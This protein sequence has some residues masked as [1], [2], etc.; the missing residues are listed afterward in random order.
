MPNYG[1]HLARTQ[2]RFV[3]AL[4]ELFLPL[5]AARKIQCARRIP[6]DVFSYSGQRRLAEQVVSIRSFLQNAGR[7]N[8]F[9]VVSDGS[10]SA[11]N[12]ELLRRIDECVAVEQV[13]AP[14]ADAS[15][16]LASYLRTHP[17]GKQL[18]LVMSLPRE[19]PALYIDSDVLFFAAA[20]GLE[21]YAG[22][23]TAPAYYLQDCG[24]AGDE[25]LL[26]GDNEKSAPV[27]TGVLLVRRRLDWSTGINRFAQLQGEPN[28]FTN[29]TLTHLT[30]HANG[31][32]PFDPAKYVLQLDDQFIY[33]DCYAGPDLALRHYVDP[34]RH[35][36]W[37]SLTH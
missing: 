21:T 1:Y 22:N 15:P 27:N 14:A 7:P 32:Q 16:S 30:M 10:Y 4:N 31:A 20:P 35:K 17:T 6:I 8:R 37:T 3:Q 25:R 9:V 24:F 28:F 34:V 33:A 19:Q 13:P 26:R 2:G 36:F 23:E 29:Q 12:I 5:I 18:A 11:K